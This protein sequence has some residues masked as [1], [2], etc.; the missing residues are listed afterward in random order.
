M[1]IIKDQ[2]SFKQEKKK[3][4]Y[5]EEALQAEHKLASSYHQLPTNGLRLLWVTI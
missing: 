3:E 1:Q 2:F 4:I 5:L